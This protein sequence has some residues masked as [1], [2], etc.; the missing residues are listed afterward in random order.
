MPQLDPVLAT[1][2]KVLIPHA[3]TDSTCSAELD[4]AKR[5]YAEVC[6]P[7]AQQLDE[8]Q[9]RWELMRPVVNGK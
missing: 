5:N 1:P 7:N 6:V 2:A 8:L 4:V 9:K 3:E